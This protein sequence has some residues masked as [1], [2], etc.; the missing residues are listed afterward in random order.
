V[1]VQRFLTDVE[2]TR[3][4]AGWVLLALAGFVTAALAYGSFVSGRVTVTTIVF[5]AVF[6]GLSALAARLAFRRDVVIEIDLDQRRYTVI[7]RGKPAAAGALDDLGPLVVS[8]R[9]RT[10]G[11]GSNRRTV[12]EYPVNPSAHAKI[13]LYVQ[14]SASQARR[15]AEALARAWGLPCRSLG[16]EVRAPKDLDT[17]LHERLRDDAEAAASRPLRPEWGVRIEP[18]F[19]GHAMISTHRAYGPL[20]QSAFLA[21]LP[22][23]VLVGAIRGG[24]IAPLPDSTGDLLDRVFFGLMAVVAVALIW[25]LAQGARD[26]F[27]PGTVHVTDRGVAYRGRRMTF[28]DIEEIT[29]VVPIEVV[30]DRRTLTLPASFCPPAAA[31]AVAHELQRLIV[32]V[33]PKWSG[34]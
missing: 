10:S 9:I 5:I 27:F 26:T 22:M 19:R 8:E 1:A 3:R 13:D 11:T 28:A 2:R 18:V 24:L 30:G 21:L 33:A 32:E 23:V 20:V 34:G 14:T 4:N 29:A 6:A 25:K 31:G 12:R 15:K 17:P 7:R 16:G